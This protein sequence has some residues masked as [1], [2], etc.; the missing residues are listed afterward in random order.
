MHELVFKKNRRITRTSI[1]WSAIIKVLKINFGMLTTN[2]ISVLRKIIVILQN[3]KKTYLQ[4]K[5]QLLIIILD[6]IIF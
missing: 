6:Q 1:N 2:G 5:Y 4:C 3:L